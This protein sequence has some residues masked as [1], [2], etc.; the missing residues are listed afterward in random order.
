MEKT[1]GKDIQDQDRPLLLFKG[2]DFV[3]HDPDFHSPFTR[4]K[5]L[6]V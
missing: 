4:C 6:V 1:G 5:P 2:D 3:F